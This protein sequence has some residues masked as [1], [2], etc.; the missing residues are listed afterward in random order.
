[1]VRKLA[2]TGMLVVGAV[3][4]FG[5]STAFASGGEDNNTTVNK[6]VAIAVENSKQVAD[7]NNNLVQAIATLQADFQANVQAVGIDQDAVNNDWTQLNTAQSQL[8]N[9]VGAPLS[10]TDVDALQSAEAKLKMDQEAT[11]V[12]VTKLNS[13]EKSDQDAVTQAHAALTSAINQGVAQ[14]A[15]QTVCS[16]INNTTNNVTNNTTNVTNNTTTAASGGGAGSGTPGMPATG[17]A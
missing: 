16:T 12:A 4:A 9:H 17:A 11:N 1:M 8:A 14:T 6:C 10:Q 7:L 2:A 5:V 15:N 13:Q 3:F